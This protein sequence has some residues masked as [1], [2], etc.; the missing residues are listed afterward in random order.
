MAV[1]YE[2]LCGGLDQSQAAFDVGNTHFFGIIDHLIDV[3]GKTAIVMAV[4]V[5]LFNRVEKTFMDTV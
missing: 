1:I 5:L 4:G 3:C 2:P